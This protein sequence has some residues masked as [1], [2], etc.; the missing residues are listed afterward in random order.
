MYRPNKKIHLLEKHGVLGEAFT[1]FAQ[2]K[3]IEN[4]SFKTQEIYENSWKFFGP[5]LEKFGTMTGDETD[6][7]T[8]ANRKAWEKRIVN[9]IMTAIDERQSGEK[10]VSPITVNVY[11][12]VIN[13]FLRWLNKEDEYL[14]FA[15]KVKELETP[16][17]DRR[18]IFSD[19]DVAA[20]QKYKP[21]SFSQLRAW[22]IAMLML[23]SGIRI[24]EALGLAV[25][26]I[27]YDSDILRI[28]G[29]GDKA[30]AVPISL[31]KPILYRWVSKHMPPTAKF[32][33]GTASGKMLSQRNALRDLAVVMSKAKMTPHSWHSFRHT[34]ATGYLRRDG[35]IDKLQRIMGH[36][37]IRTTMIYLHMANEYLTDDHEMHSSLTPI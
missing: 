23:D 17:G 31:I 21:T 5:H 26:D 8:P 20:L 27:D 2:M 25:A 6:F 13:T 11:L 37:D 10:P 15:W 36:A 19:D 18:E 1:R 30:R 9:L 3:R 14:Q 4:V 33:F 24:E 7:E 29:K 12:R 32:V 34:F 16:K 22:T 35:K 28:V